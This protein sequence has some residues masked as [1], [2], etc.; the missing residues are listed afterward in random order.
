MPAGSSSCPS[1]SSASTVFWLWVPRF[2]LHRKI[3]LRAL[4]PGALLA[5]V[6]V[7]GMTATSPL[8]CR[9]PLNANGKAFGSFGVVVTMIGYVFVMITLSLVCAVF[10]PVWAGWRESERQRRDAAVRGSEAMT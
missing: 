3:G 5:T 2:L 8:F 10:S 7:G 4:L 9:R 1:G 6:V